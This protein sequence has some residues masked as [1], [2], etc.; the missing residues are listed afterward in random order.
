MRI[1]PMLITTQRRPAMS[2][3]VILMAMFSV[4]CASSQPAQSA[5]SPSHS[6]SPTGCETLIFHHDI[7]PEIVI[8]VGSFSVETGKKIANGDSTTTGTYKEDGK[9]MFMVSIRVIRKEDGAVL[10]QNFNAP[11]AAIEF[12]TGSPDPPTGT[13][14]SIKPGE[15]GGKTTIELVS[16]HPLQI[17]NRNPLQYRRIQKLENRDLRI[18]NVK[19]TKGGKT[20]FSYDTSTNDQCRVLIQVEGCVPHV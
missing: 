12:A 8:D 20:L 6:P 5:A 10:Y 17:E 19:V 15:Q 11:G 7:P 9:H 14:I 3:M 18:N 13:S 4:S 2:L 16:S 1:Q